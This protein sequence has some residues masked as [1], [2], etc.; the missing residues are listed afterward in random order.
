MQTRK[1]I[2]SHIYREN[3]RY[4]AVHSRDGEQIFT[5]YRKKEGPL[6]FEGAF[7]CGVIQFERECLHVEYGESS[8]TVGPWSA[9]LAAGAWRA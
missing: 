2:L 8:Q 9:L 3:A 7:F 4:E 5:F 6:C 1:A